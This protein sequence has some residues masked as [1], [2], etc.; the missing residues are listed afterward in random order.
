MTSIDNVVSSFLEGYGRALS[1]G[2]SHAIVNCW[3]VPALVLAD[4]GARMV[5]EAAE[6]EQFFIGAIEWYRAQGMVAT[7]PSS[8]EI[9]KLS[10]RLLSVDARWSVIDATGAESPGEH[11]YYILSISDNGLPHIRVAI[12]LANE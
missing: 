2:D 12:S 7:K 11:S 1:T 10:E 6:V 9:K 3:E 8:V 4:Q 5:N